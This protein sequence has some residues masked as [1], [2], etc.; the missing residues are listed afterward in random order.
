MAEVKGTITK[1]KI[2]QE[3]EDAIYNIGGSGG[4]SG[5]S[6]VKSNIFRVEIP[7]YAASDLKWKTTSYGYSYTLKEKKLSNIIDNTVVNIDLNIESKDNYDSLIES[8]SY[9]YYA[10]AKEGELVLHAK[11]PPKVNTPIKI[12]WLSI[13]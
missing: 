2:N 13:N 11:E 1:L 12:T 5:G 7:K 9:F 6:T 3:G 10:E 8:Y 4:G